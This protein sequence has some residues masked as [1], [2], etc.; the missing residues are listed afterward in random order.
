MNIEH[1]F[2][3]T[4]PSY[5]ICALMNGDTSGMEDADE[6]AFNA[7]LEREKG[8]DVWQIKEEE[9]GYCEPYFSNH[10]EFGLPCDCVDV[11]GI[12]FEKGNTNNE[13]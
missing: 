6:K 3:Y 12:V 2:E 1:E 13:H 11:V 9:D 5:A 4:F 7:F 8:I 10:P